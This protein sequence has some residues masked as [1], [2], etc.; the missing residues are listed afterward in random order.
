M[1]GIEDGVD[2]DGGRNCLG[3]S[4]RRSQSMAHSGAAN[5]ARGR[6]ARVTAP[7]C[8]CGKTHFQSFVRLHWHRQ[9][10]TLRSRHERNEKIMLSP[11][12][13]RIS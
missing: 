6:D 5:G 8:L 3:I 7:V 11:P 12:N 4:A 10:L 13:N 2:L 9:C 1:D